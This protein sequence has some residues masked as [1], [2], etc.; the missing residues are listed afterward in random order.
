MGTRRQGPSLAVDPVSPGTGAVAVSS[1]T[2]IAAVIDVALA[3][4]LAFADGNTF[5][6]PAST[7]FIV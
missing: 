2:V 7:R 6:A 1:A 4:V 5:V 3:L